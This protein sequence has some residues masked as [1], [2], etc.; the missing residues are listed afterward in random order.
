[1]DKLKL[2]N[3]TLLAMTSVLID[4]TILALKYSSKDIEFGSVKLISHEKPENLPSDIT[5]QY[6]S[7]IGSIDSWNQK[8]VFE[9][10]K[11]VDTDFVLLIHDDGF[12]I[13]VNSW[14]DE[15]LD[16]DYI[17]APWGHNHL[18][19]SN[20]VPIKVGN[21]VS[22]R[23]KKL[24]ELPTKYNMPWR[25]HD[26]NFNEDTQICVWNRNFFLNYGI[27]YADYEIAKYFSHEEILPG[28][29]EIIPFCFH[30][31]EGENRK[32]KKIFEEYKYN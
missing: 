2:P 8:I 17:G 6:I 32:Y 3:V 25:P 27:K 10:Y 13:N 21:S 16:Y 29:N 15:F 12:V 18:L 11:Y 26:N 9:L 5:Y 4:E 1:M 22:I 7:H 20:G 24:L 31:F 14:K 23:S 28:F 30:S 19:D